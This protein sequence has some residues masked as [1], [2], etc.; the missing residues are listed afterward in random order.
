MRT[1]SLSNKSYRHNVF[2]VHS[3][4]SRI[5]VSAHAPQDEMNV[6]THQASAEK[7]GPRLSLRWVEVCDVCLT[8]WLHIAVHAFEELDFARSTDQPNSI[9]LRGPTLRCSNHLQFNP[10]QTRW[11]R[12]IDDHRGSVKPC[13]TCWINARVFAQVLR[14]SG[15]NGCRVFCE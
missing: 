2:T 10:S 1:T 6:D 8:S 14:A 12:E 11:R 5:A 15:R 9:G 7:K 13:E 3:N 4:L